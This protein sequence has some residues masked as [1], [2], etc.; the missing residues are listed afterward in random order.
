MPNLDKA[1]VTLR[2]DVL[3]V[4]SFITLANTP[5]VHIVHVPSEMFGPIVAAL[6]YLKELALVKNRVMMHIRVF[7]NAIMRG[8]L[9]SLGGNLLSEQ[10][11]SPD[12]RFLAKLVDKQRKLLE[13]MR[14]VEIRHFL[15]YIEPTMTT[16]S[17]VQ[18]GISSERISGNFGV[19]LSKAIVAPR[20]IVLTKNILDRVRTEFKGKKRVLVVVQFLSLSGN[21]SERESVNAELHAFSVFAQEADVSVIALFNDISLIPKN[22]VASAW[23]VAGVDEVFKEAVV[24]A[25]FSKRKPNFNRIESPMEEL[26]MQLPGHAAFLRAPLLEYLTSKGEN[27]EKTGSM[28]GRQLTNFV[29]EI[30]ENT[31]NTLGVHLR[32]IINI[33]DPEVSEVVAA[34]AGLL[35]GYYEG[36][37]Y[38][39]KYH[40]HN[41]F[42]ARPLSAGYTLRLDI[43]PAVK[44]RAKRL[45]KE[46]FLEPY[47]VVMNSNLEPPFNVYV[48]NVIMA[49]ALGLALLNLLSDGKDEILDERLKLIYDDNFELGFVHGLELSRMWFEE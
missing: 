27:L 37:M 23:S 3:S 48:A 7:V 5:G 39:P 38:R 42:S 26:A 22:L 24:R 13:T 41:K 30:I 33:G 40:K 2:K 45:V 14:R 18:S 15:D 11:S 43:T 25:H 35:N 29:K 47:I 9:K 28:T 32:G 19:S 10:P 21:D 12:L 31:A 20:D 4:V 49:G 8:K 34:L 1:E 36:I 46:L 17:S 44:N 6:F 16:Q